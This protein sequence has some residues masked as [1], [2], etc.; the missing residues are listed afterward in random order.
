[1]ITKEDILNF[2]PT[3]IATTL[4][5]MR[6]VPEDKLDFTLHERSSSIRALFRTFI[7]E[8]ISNISILKGEVPEDPMSKVSAF[9]TVAEGITAFETA[10]NE[11]VAALQ[12][13]SEADIETA[14]S[15]WGLNGTRGTIL[16]GMM[17][18]MIHHRGQLS[19]YLR[20]AGGRVPMIYGPSGDEGFAA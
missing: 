11:F 8:V 9:E 10:S 2:Y 15:M 5:V 14:F 7:V 4:K 17:S 20:P 16:L 1:M 19:A 13:T 6:A 3:E 12:A 18:D